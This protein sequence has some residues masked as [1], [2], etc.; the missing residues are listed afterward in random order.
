[1]VS[2]SITVSPP[3]FE[4]S[5][6]IFSIPAAFL[7]FRFLS[8]ASTSSCSI[9]KSLSFDDSW[10]MIT[11]RSPLFWR[12]YGSE[13]HSVHL[14][15]RY[16]FNYKIPYVKYVYSDTGSRNLRCTRMQRVWSW[17]RLKNGRPIGGNTGGRL[18]STTSV[19]NNYYQQ[20]ASPSTWWSYALQMVWNGNQQFVAKSIYVN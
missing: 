14:L 17:D 19:T 5:A 13:Q 16:Q 4:S 2:T 3:C 12:L 15:P 1:M 10:Q 6:E 7:H 18:W 20:I 11:L 8:T 9:G